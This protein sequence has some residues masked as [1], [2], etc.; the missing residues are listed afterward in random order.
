MLQPGRVE[1]VKTA[2]RVF[3]SFVL[4]RKSEY[5]IAHELNEERIFNEFGR[6]WRM[7]AIRRLLTCEKCLGHYVYNRKS[8]K[9]RSTRK[10]NPPAS[11]VRYDDAFESIISPVRECRKII[12]NRPRRTIRAWKSDAE[13]LSR[14][15]ALLLKKGRLTSRIIE[16]SDDLPCT[17]TYILSASGPCDGPMS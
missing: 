10:S 8:G 6:P 17:Q 12:E 9:L 11:W 13:M 7:L 5:T 14:L 1:E 3:R 16:N 4:E 2:R 15:S